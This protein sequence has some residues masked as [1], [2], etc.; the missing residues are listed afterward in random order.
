MCHTKL[1]VNWTVSLCTDPNGSST[2]QHWNVGSYCD[3]DSLFFFIIKCDDSCCCRKPSNNFIKNILILLASNLYPRIRLWFFL[4]NFTTYLLEYKPPFLFYKSFAL[5]LWYNVII[6]YGIIFHFVNT[7]LQSMSHILNM[8]C[9]LLLTPWISLHL[10][11]PSET[12]NRSSSIEILW[13]YQPL[14]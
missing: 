5:N 10:I 2:C 13:S 11:L 7:I 14:Q 1:F 9:P 8:D 3:L 12:G 6:A 4:I